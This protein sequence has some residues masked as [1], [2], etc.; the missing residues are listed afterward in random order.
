MTELH[1]K[2]NKIQEI[3]AH[4]MWPLAMAVLAMVTCLPGLR[5]GLF[6]DDFLQRVELI[7]PNQAH[8]ALS[9]V[10]LDVNEPGH[11]PTCLSDLFIAVSPGK[12]RTALL[13][14][15]A[16]PWWTGPHYKVSLLR[17]L[18]T[19]THWMDAHWLG[20]SVRWMH[21]HN[22][23]WLGLVFLLAGVIYRTIMP[24]GLACAGLALLFLALDS[25][26]YFPTLWIANRNQLMALF[27]ALLSL[28]MFHLWRVK[29]CPFCAILSGLG[30]TAS[31]LSAEG[32]IATFAFL[33]AYA[34]CL[35]SGTWKKR[36]LSL[37]PSVALIIL[38]RVA[39]SHF[40]YGAQGGGFYLDPAGQPLAFAQAA[41]Q[42]GAFLLAGQWYAIPPDL[43]AFVHDAARLPFTLALW[44]LLITAVVMCMP[45]LYHDRTARFWC[46]AMGSA[47]VPVCA[48]VPMGRNL[49][50][51]SIA[52]FALTA[53]FIHGVLT[54]AAWLPKA[55]IR[56][57]LTRLTAWVLILLHGALGIAATVAMPRLTQN[58]MTEMNATCDLSAAAP[59]GNQDLVIINAPNPAS[60]I[61]AP[62]KQALTS[63]PL[64]RLIHMLAPGYGPLQV[65][66]T[67][68]QSLRLK[69][70][71][72]SL[73]TC[74]I[75]P[76]L[77]IVHLYRYLSDFRAPQDRF[78]PGKAIR[79]PG[80]TVFIESMDTQGQPVEIR[81]EFDSPLADA[82]RSWLRWD[83]QLKCYEPFDLPA[84]GQTVTLKGP[85]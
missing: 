64:P 60:M 80:L 72:A 39:Y 16:M 18:A 45:L 56:L 55:K 14:Y 15:G 28:I 10:G 19:L 22:V 62:Y 81:C 53:L 65:S 85:Y 83:W 59:S 34:L 68:D 79:L 76:R 23:I 13:N 48:A 66:R 2:Q 25:N 43:F 32:G 7:G 63:Q 8:R 37:M 51:A 11:L 5:T 46:V 29:R 82:T 17:P 1:T 57:W 50:F 75:T 20:D 6:N 27:F 24:S 71:E 21:A 44:G 52:G 54:R 26:H 69:A 38:W 49:L 61:Y 58:M 4:R 12:N 70:L 67:D 9:E 78:T 36:A 77:E 47:M 74:Q 35:D 30:L 84:V 73:L 33:F 3:L 40:G 42:R 41:L 31:V